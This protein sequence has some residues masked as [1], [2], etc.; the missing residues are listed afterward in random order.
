MVNRRRMMGNLFYKKGYCPHCGHSKCLSHLNKSSM[1]FN[2]IICTK[3]KRENKGFEEF[4]N[5]NGKQ[6]VRVKE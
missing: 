1:L 4:V 6:C 3:C 5:K 2:K